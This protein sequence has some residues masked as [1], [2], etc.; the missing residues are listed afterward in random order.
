MDK[1]KNCALCGRLPEI[2][3][4]AVLALGKYGAPRYLCEECEAELDTATLGTEYDKIVDSIDRLGK[5]AMGFGKD[6][7]VTLR[8]MKSIL[9]SAA[10]RAAAIKEG[11]YDFALDEEQVT[12]GYDELPEE[13]RETEEDAELDRREAES[14]KKFDKVLNWAWVGIFAGVIILFLLKFVFRVI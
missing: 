9:E 7:P 3:E 13:L 6:D 5:K 2:E 14:A 8:T 11:S 12:E 1:N 4:P 10:K